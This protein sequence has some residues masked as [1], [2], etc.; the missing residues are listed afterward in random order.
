MLDPSYI[1]K[2]TARLTVLEA[3]LSDPGTAA[4][5]KKYRALVAEHLNLRHVHQTWPN[6]ISGWCASATRARRSRTAT[7][8][9]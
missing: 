7:T 1:E 5:Q 4:N 9:R 2:L 3:E 6:A 8:P